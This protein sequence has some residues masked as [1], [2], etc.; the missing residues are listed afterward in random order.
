MHIAGLVRQP[1]G[2]SNSTSRPDPR[3]PGPDREGFVVRSLDGSKTD[4]RTDWAIG[5]ICRRGGLP[6]EGFQR[7]RHVRYPR[8][9]VRREPVAPAGVDG[10]QAH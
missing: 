8:R 6:V 3:A 9:T 1:Y 10:P 4:G 7:L 2:T 5:R